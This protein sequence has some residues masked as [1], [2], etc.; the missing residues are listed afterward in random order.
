[1]ETFR[2]RRA[3]RIGAWV[4][5]GLLSLAAGGAAAAPREW[6]LVDIGTL[7]GPG[8]YGSAVSDN[9]IVVGCSDVMPNGVHAFVY[10]DGVLQDLGTGNATASGNSCA[11]AVNTAGAV[12]GRSATG[13]LVLWQGGSVT[14]LGVQ[15]NVGGMNEAGA[16]V[17][18]YQ[19]GGQARAFLYRSGVLSDLGTLGGEGATAANAVNDRAEVVGSSNGR[20]FL[21]RDGTMRDLGTLG[22]NRSAARAVNGSGTV[23]GMAANEFGQPGPFIYDGVMRALPAGNYSEAVGINQRLQV[24]GTGEGRYGYL[25]DGGEV[26]PLDTLAAVQAKGWHHLQ[27]T[28]INNQGW[29]VGTAF[30]AQGDSRAFL[31]V[32]REAGLPIGRPSTLK[33]TRR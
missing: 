32:P 18:S 3:A 6:T 27:P 31:L 25:V 7:G 15:G 21:Y 28:G 10:R 13:E 23:V 12:A 2:G 33:F 4:A 24:V 16:V 5:A 1:M 14:G 30:N 8:S 17:G 29:I 9:G 11:L 26:T 20:A 22:G 19:S